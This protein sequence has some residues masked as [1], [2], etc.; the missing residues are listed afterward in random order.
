M[1]VEWAA[2]LFSA[3][4]S[5]AVFVQV[6][7]VLGAPWGALTMGGRW[8]GVMPPAARILSLFQAALLVALA[9]IVLAQAGLLGA[10]PPQWMLW[11]A[12]VITCLS[13]IANIVTPSK[14]ERRLW[15]PIMVMM[16]L[17]F[18]VVLVY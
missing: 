7:L 17:C 10:R 9:G 6:A 2:G 14:P 11:T 8:P 16:V 12:A 5:I 4:T 15:A 18:G 1:I 13:T 3:L